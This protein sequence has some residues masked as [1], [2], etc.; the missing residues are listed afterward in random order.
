MFDQ[1][2]VVPVHAGSDW[3][4]AGH[5]PTYHQVPAAAPLWPL[6][7]AGKRPTTLPWAYVACET[8]SQGHS[9]VKECQSCWHN[10]KGIYFFIF[11]S[12]D[13]FEK[14]FV[15]CDKL[16]ASTFAIYELLYFLR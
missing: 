4:A 16:T 7:A 6:S 11:L 13:N 12:K 10:T 8:L 3:G 14:A 9:E 5:D 2:C 1:Y 15:L